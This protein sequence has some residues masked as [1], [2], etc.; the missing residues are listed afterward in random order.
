MALTKKA[1]QK[2]LATCPHCAAPFDRL[3]RT[4]ITQSQKAELVHV[5]CGACQGSLLALLFSTGPYISSIGLI[6]DLSREDV[7]HFQGSQVLAE[8][9]LFALHNWLQQPSAVTDVLT[10]AVLH[11]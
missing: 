4:T 10:Y 1:L 7:V 6:S 8:D 9:D 5:R 3:V 2:L 11:S